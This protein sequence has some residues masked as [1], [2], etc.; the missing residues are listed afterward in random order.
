MSKCYCFDLFYKQYRTRYEY[1]CDSFPQAVEALSWEDSRIRV[2]TRYVVKRLATNGEPVVARYNMIS[3]EFPLNLIPYSK[4]IYYSTIFVS[5][6]KFCEYLDDDLDMHK[7]K[8]M[9]KKNIK[10]LSKLS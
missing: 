10:N 9:I 1:K 5:F 8:K 3:S 6:S 7:E 2:C 4:D